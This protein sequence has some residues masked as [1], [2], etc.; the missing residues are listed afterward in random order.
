MVGKTSQRFPEKGI[1][2]LVY[3]KLVIARLKSSA[4]DGVPTIGEIAPIASN[5]CVLRNNRCL[6][7]FTDRE[8]SLLNVLIE[9]SK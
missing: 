5:S 8:Q 3:E 2:T 6:A 4:K 1:W 7:E 9:G